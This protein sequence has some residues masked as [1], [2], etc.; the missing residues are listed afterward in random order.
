MNGKCFAFLSVLGCALATWAQAP[1]TLTGVRAIHDL[2]RE[3]AARGVPVRFEGTVTYFRDSERTMFVQDGDAAVFVLAT[4]KSAIVPGDRVLIQGVTGVGMNAFAVSDNFVLLHHGSLPKAV[5]AR[6]EELIRAQRDCQLV[7]VRGVVRSAD[8]ER[9]TNEV[10]PRHPLVSGGRLE[11]LTEGGMIEALMDSGDAGAISGLLDATVELTGAAGGIFD[12]KNR[13]TGVILHVTGLNQVRIL[14]RSEKDPWKLPFTSMDRVIS[15]NRIHDLSERVRVQGTVTYYEPGLA[16]V[17]QDGASSIWVATKFSGTLRTYDRVEA[18]GFP[19]VRDGFLTLSLGEVRDT[20][21]SAWI[22]AHPVK[23]RE[24]ASSKHLFDLVSIEGQVVTEVQEATQDEYILSADG[25][26]FSAFHSRPEKGLPPMRPIPIGSKVRVTGVCI[27]A[28]SNPFIPEVPFNLL[29]RTFDDIEVVAEPSPL[30]IRNLVLAVCLLLVVV[31]LFGTR[32]WS[33]ERR[34]RRQTAAMSARTEAEAAIERR[35]SA[36]LEDIN[37]SR[38]LAEI[39][40][41]IVAMVSTRLGGAP[42][43]YESGDGSMM[44]DRPANVHGLRTVRV[45]IEG[46][47]GEA[48]GSL[49]A[50]FDP[51][52]APGGLETEALKSGARLASLAIDTRRLYVDL[53]HRSEY[54]LLTDIHNR[55]SLEKHLEAHMAEAKRQG[56]IFGLIYFDIDRFKEVNDLYGHHVGDMYLKEVA[57]RL[58][59]QLRSDD[60]LARLGGDEFAAMTPL[61]SSRRHVEEIA[62]RLQGCFDTPFILGEHLL[63]GSASIGIALYPKDGTTKDSLLRSA[64]EAMYAVKNGKRQVGV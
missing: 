19:D 46:R 62:R 33:L 30:N 45:E 15:G 7:S 14:H 57:R 12:G 41:E 11:V 13:Q 22:P 2:N 16:V 54:D 26:L 49:V 60:L 21:E 50:G 5:P 31:A 36:I 23:W 40:V 25:Q 8:V 37:G 6:Y 58:K 4:P 43:W 27:L 56:V 10:D 59:H 32:G 1:A 20:N 18:T 38:P 24:L 3:I 55:F 9:R 29:L 39:L 35:R 53:F 34:M 51:A 64:D 47:S 28:N 17:L 63:H 48:Q 42:C 61:L 52:A 44:G